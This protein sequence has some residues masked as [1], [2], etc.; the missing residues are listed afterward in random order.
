M[1]LLAS[2]LAREGHNLLTSGGL[3]TNAAV[4]R[5]V[6][7]VKPSALTV[8]LPQSLSRQTKESRQQMEHVLHLVEK[9]EHDHLPLQEASRPLQQGDY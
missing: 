1:E 5:G 8:V 3:G 9:P 7:A 2:A 6:L 4:I